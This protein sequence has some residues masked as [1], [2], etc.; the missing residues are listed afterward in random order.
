MHARIY[1]VPIRC[2]VDDA[3]YI[4]L[5]LLV[6]TRSMIH[7]HQQSGMPMAHVHGLSPGVRSAPPYTTYIPIPT[8]RAI[9]T[10]NKECECAR[11]VIRVRLAIRYTMKDLSQR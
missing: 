5:F 4:Y 2:H 8:N 11:M 3:Y 10:R 9:G 1:D 7:I 6:C